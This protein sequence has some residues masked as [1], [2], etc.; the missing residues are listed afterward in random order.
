[1]PNILTLDNFIEEMITATTL[2]GQITSNM[3]AANIP[4]SHAPVDIKIMPKIAK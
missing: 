3:Y 4:T 2:I 1:M